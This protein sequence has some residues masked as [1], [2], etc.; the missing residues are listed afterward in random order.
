MSY[1]AQ[2]LA[3]LVG[4]YDRAGRVFHD[5][6]Y[7]AHKKSEKRHHRTVGH[8]Q[9]PPHGVLVLRGGQQRVGEVMEQRDFFLFQHRL[10]ERPYFLRPETGN[11]NIYFVIDAAARVKTARNGGLNNSATTQT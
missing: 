11:V 2:G 3:V 9:G 7:F 8:C 6:P 5:F 10:H 4:Q 1:L